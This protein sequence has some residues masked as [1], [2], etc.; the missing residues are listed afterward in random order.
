MVNT[1]R[2][3]LMKIAACVSIDLNNNG[4][5]EKHVLRLADAC[6][7]Q[8]IS[9]DVF[10]KTGPT[11]SSDHFYPLSEMEISQYDIIHTH[12]G[13]YGPRFLEMQLKRQ[14]HQRFVHTLHGVSLNYLFG[15]KAWLNWRC[16]WSTFIEGMW[17]RYADHVIAVSNSDKRWA[18]SSF[19][20]TPSKLSVINNGIVPSQFDG[21][22]E[23]DMRKMLGLSE[24]NKVILFVGRGEDR[25]KGTQEITESMEQ[26]YQEFPD[27]RLMAIPG[28][29][30]NGA[31]WSCKTGPI[32]HQKIADCYKAADIFVNA[33]MS[34]SFPLTVVEAMGAG[35]P[36]VASPVGGIPDMIQNQQNGL[37]LKPDRTDLTTQL[38]RLILDQPL[39]EKLSHNATQSAKNYNWQAIA[40]QTI[41]VYESLY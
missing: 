33:S 25:V 22:A 4:G 5:V 1:H 41:Q 13:Y 23:S 9:V 16:Y 11:T 3:E 15:C 34:E 32:D 29:G 30:F 6:R 20:V 24:D 21:P 39:C 37:L 27:V 28:T 18:L 40:Q 26:L 2:K 17:S 8:G 35:L 36:I 7:L 10:A 19:K 38:R 14:R 12:S 31:P